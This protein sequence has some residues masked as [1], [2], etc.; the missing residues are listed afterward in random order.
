MHEDEEEEEEEKGASAKAIEINYHQHSKKTRARA[1]SV[2]RQQ[3]NVAKLKR[4][5]LNQGNNAQPLFPAIRLIH[6]PHSLAEKL[7]KRLRQS[8]ERFEVKLLLMNFIS[9]LIGCHELLLLSFYSFLQRYLTSHQ[10]DVTVI[11]TYLIQACHPM[12]PPDEITP[13]MR[14][15]SFNFITERC[16]N[17]VI[18]VG[19]NSIR[20]IINRIPAILR[21]PGMDDFIQDLA[22]YGKKT[23]KSVMIAAHGV[24]NLVREIYPTLLRKG[25]RGKYYNPDNLPVKYGEETVASGVAGVELLEAYERGE[26]AID[27]DGEVVWK[28]EEQ[29]DDDD[30]SDA[31]DLVACDDDESDAS[32]SV[33]GDE[34]EDE[35]EE[36]VDASNSGSEASEDEDDE[37]DSECDEHENTSDGNSDQV[38][39]SNQQTTRIDAKRLLTPEDF[40]LLERLKAA[41]KE[42]ME[43]PKFR[44]KRK[45]SSLDDGDDADK[46]FALSS[47]ILAPE[48]KVGK[49][50][51]IERITNVLNGRKDKKFEHEGHAGGLTNKEKSRKKNYM[52]IRKGKSA[53]TKKS[54]KSNSEVRWQKH[55]AKAPMGRD[56]RK[57]RRT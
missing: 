36:E 54:R 46:S 19:I 37:D 5:K 16:S 7:F 10:Q 32:G 21:E 48:A 20:E 23:H 24:I 11:L 14:A 39:Q 43:D 40:E 17:E 15:I 18:A 56:K 50:S 27:S 29:D 51:K 44:S 6:D 41:Q 55:H 53:V 26:I 47:S 57:R 3:V 1:R 49:S 8:C 4:E 38:T 34:N 9:R 42:R 28:D 2:K 33:S 30:A 25:S 31:P 35:D 45:R 52:M 22:Q 12:V 13:V